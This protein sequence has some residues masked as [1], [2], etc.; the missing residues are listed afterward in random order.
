[1]LIITL[2]NHD[3]KTETEVNRKK[4]KVPLLN[5]TIYYPFWKCDCLLQS[6]VERK[7]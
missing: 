4:A 3:V 7:K 6:S 1:M 2:A 5:I